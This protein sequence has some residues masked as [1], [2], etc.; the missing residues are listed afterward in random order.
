MLVYPDPAVVSG[1]DGRD[2]WLH[3]DSLDDRRSSGHLRGREGGQGMRSLLVG[4]V[5]LVAG[6]R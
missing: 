6:R 1:T 4:R 2:R 3:A 5:V